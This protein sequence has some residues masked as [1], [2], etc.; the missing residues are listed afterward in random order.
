M[1][2]LTSAHCGGQSPPSR[3]GLGWLPRALG[4]VFPS[5]TAPTLTRGPG[6]IPL[7]FVRVPWMA[8][9]ACTPL[10]TSSSHP[11]SQGCLSYGVRMSV[12]T[13][14]PTQAPP[15]ALGVGTLTH[16]L[17]GHGSSLTSC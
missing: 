3:C 9:S 11:R 8:S 4:R 1:D 7:C 5:P 6:G 2:E 13:L 14:W 15:H 12:P 17:E 16:P 10:F